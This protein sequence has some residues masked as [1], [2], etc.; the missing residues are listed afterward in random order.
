VKLLLAHI[1]PHV[2]QTHVQ[3]WMTRKPHT[4]NIKKRRQ[5]LL[6]HLNIDMLKRDDVADIFL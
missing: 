6:R 1:G 4:D 3:V 5:G 2:A